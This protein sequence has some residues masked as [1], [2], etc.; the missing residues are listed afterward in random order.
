MMANHMYL[1]YLL[2]IFCSCTRADEPVMV[3]TANGP[4]LGSLRNTM[5]PSF[6]SYLSFQ[7]IPF[8]EPPVGP[9]R[10][11]PTQPPSPWT[12]PLDLTGDTDIICPQLSETVSG[13]L[14]GQ[15]DCLYMNIYTPNVD[16][17]GNDLLPVMVW[18]YGGGFITGS[19]IMT[20]YGPEKWLD[21][22]IVVVTVNYRYHVFFQIISCENTFF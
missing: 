6:T 3:Q 8:A 11:L 1:L 13:D 2:G 14:L 18:I 16:L 21:Q 4:I 5:L 10:L 15:E 19:G 12:E 22:G 20:E 17:K 7:G 9:L